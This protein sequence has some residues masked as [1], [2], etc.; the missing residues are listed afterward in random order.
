MSSGEVLFL[1]LAIRIRLSD[2]SPTVSEE[3]ALCPIHFYTRKGNGAL[4]S[5]LEEWG[6]MASQLAILN[7]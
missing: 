7:S 1:S 5:K 2:A 3:R 4:H 6:D